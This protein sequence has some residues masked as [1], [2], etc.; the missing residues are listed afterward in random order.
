MLVSGLQ[1]AALALQDEK[2]EVNGMRI[3]TRGDRDEKIRE[4]RAAFINRLH[5]NRPWAYYLGL[6]EVLNFINILTQIYLT[7]WFLG[8]AFLGLGNELKE[9]D[10]GGKMNPLDEIFPKVIIKIST[11]SF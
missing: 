1:L 2:I 7:D 6:Y 11:F 3:P 5:L 10:F 8:G 9:A 4:I